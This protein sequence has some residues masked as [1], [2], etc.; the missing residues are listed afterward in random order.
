MSV[1]PKPRKLFK[2]EIN[3]IQTEQQVN[4]WRT[5]YDQQHSSDEIE[6]QVVDFIHQHL[7]QTWFP[8][9][10]KNII[11]NELGLSELFIKVIISYDF[12]SL[13][14]LLDV[15][16]VEYQ[17][18]KAEIEKL[19]LEFWVLKQNYLADKIIKFKSY[20]FSKE[21]YYQLFIWFLRFLNQLEGKLEVKRMEFHRFL[22]LTKQFKEYQYNLIPMVILPKDDIIKLET[23]QLILQF[24]FD[25]QVNIKNE[26]ENFIKLKQSFKNIFQSKLFHQQLS[27]I[28]QLIKY[29]SIH[30][31]MNFMQLFF[32]RIII[33]NICLFYPEFLNHNKF[34]MKDELILLLL[35]DIDIIY[36]IYF[37]LS[38]TILTLYHINIEFVKLIELISNQNQHIMRK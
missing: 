37:N 15:I 21:S 14:K 18:D 31:T 30:Y 36:S 4:Y 25:K 5:I 8:R 13:I 12:N 6:S 27:L 33:E 11:L 34:I 19:E 38:D 17:E 7:K 20:V 28:Q 24:Y 3:I 22:K 1:Q 9:F 26:E 23:Q 10:L 35:N 16:L 32:N 2:K 29:F